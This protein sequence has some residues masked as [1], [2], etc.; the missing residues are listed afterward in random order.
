MALFLSLLLFK[1]STMPYGDCSLSK[2]FDDGGHKPMN[3]AAPTTSM[4][5]VQARVLRFSRL[6]IRRREMRTPECRRH[7]LTMTRR[8]AETCRVPWTFF[9]PYRPNGCRGSMATPTIYLLPPRRFGEHGAL[10]RENEK[11]RGKTVQALAGCSSFRAAVSAVIQFSLRKKEK[12]DFLGLSKFKVH[13]RR[14]KGYTMPLA[15][16]PP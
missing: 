15:T 12:S 7:A 13:V 11:R 4:A 16:A 14:P 6:R 1:V 2:K 5:V 9:L 10:T 3:S 8:E